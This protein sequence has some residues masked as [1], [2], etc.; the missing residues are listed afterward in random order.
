MTY[1]QHFCFSTKLGLNLLL[2][3]NKAFI[4]ALM[5]MYYTDSTS[6]LV[7]YLEKEMKSVGCK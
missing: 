2:G 5:P 7:E 3:S 4:H 1:F 6:N